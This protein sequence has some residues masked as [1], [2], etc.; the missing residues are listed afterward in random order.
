MPARAR[1]D[2]SR[3][4]SELTVPQLRSASADPQTPE[5]S[6]MRRSRFR[7]FVIFLLFAVSVVN[8]IDR[9]AISYSIPQ[10]ERDLGL[11]PADAGGI[12]GAF[13]L[14]YAV[15]TLLGGIVVDR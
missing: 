10:I 12:L 4:A 8:Y 3:A 13:G 15:T 2:R 11:S 7:W 14:G 9:A 1:R 5:E 6:R